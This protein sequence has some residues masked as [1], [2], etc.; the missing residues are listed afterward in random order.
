M[1]VLLSASSSFSLRCCRH[2]HRHR[3]SNDVYCV[4]LTYPY[5]IRTRTVCASMVGT[6]Y[7]HFGRI[8]SDFVVWSVFSHR[9]SAADTTYDYISDWLVCWWCWRRLYFCR[10]LL[11]YLC[12]RR[13]LNDGK[14]SSPRMR[15]NRREKKRNFVLS[16]TTVCC[17]LFSRNRSR[18]TSNNSTAPYTK[19]WEMRTNCKLFFS[20]V[21]VDYFYYIFGCGSCI[22]F[23]WWTTNNKIHRKKITHSLTHSL[24]FIH[25]GIGQS[26]QWASREQL[27]NSTQPK[28]KW[29]KNRWK[30]RKLL[31]EPTTY[32]HT[33]GLADD[34][35]VFDGVFSLSLNLSSLTNSHM[36][37][38]PIQCRIVIK[39]FFFLFFFVVVVVV[40]GVESLFI[41]SNLLNSQCS[42]LRQ[43]RVK[44]FRQNSL[45]C[46]PCVTSWANGPF[47]NTNNSTSMCVCFD[48]RSLQSTVSRISA[49]IFAY[50]LTFYFTSQ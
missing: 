8:F 11:L 29:T 45:F 31:L 47:E 43:N 33:L 4:W 38:E 1:C 19:E 46:S 13:S 5:L 37:V 18:N 21:V 39:T 12:G 48:F 14:T 25:F 40:V 7:W 3:K 27:N 9:A 32:T 17:W 15:M 49:F 44:S 36:S 42:P 26:R 34:N 10:N 35:V 24:N 50:F 30:L 41:L 22:N 2:R 6:M 16:T 20:A 23:A 28:P